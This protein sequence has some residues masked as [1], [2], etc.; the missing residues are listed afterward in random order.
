MI[1]RQ[2]RLQLQHTRH[3][4]H[5]ARRSLDQQNPRNTWTISPNK[6]SQPGD[7][8]TTITPPYSRSG[9]KL[10]QISNSIGSGKM[11]NSVSLAVGSDGNAYAWGH[12]TSGQLGNGTSSGFNG[13]NPVPG[14]VCDPNNPEDTS[15]SLKSVQIRAGFEHSMAI[16]AQGNTWSWGWNY[17]GELGQN[18]TNDDILPPARTYNPDNPTIP[19]KASQVSAGYDTSLAV[20]SNGISWSWERNDYGQ[21]GYTNYDSSTVHRQ[22][23]KVRNPASPNNTDLSLNSTLVSAGNWDSLAIGKDGYTYAWGYN[24]YGQLGNNSYKDAYAPV[25]VEFNLS[26]VISAARFDSSP[27]TN[28]TNINNSNS[29]TV[30]TPAHVPGTVTVSVDY[31]MG[32]SGQTL[33]DTSLRYTYTPAGVLP[34][35]GGEGVMLALATG[36]TGMGAVLASRRHRREQHRL[37]HALHE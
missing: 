31:T 9:V 1:H 4:K 10:N 11:H 6:G 21:L 25:L 22:P 5:H 24:G 16:D 32:G 36:M 17:W 29:V 3:R 34:R 37:L 27:G 20:D 7:E 13:A 18:T 15:K 8:T 12:N 26:R 35:A 23:A 19:F 30:L 28:L 33:T 2:H 14:C